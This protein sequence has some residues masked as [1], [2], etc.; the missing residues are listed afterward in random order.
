MR[1]IQI[2]DTHLSPGKAH[3]V[4]NWPP[5]ARW[6]AEQRPDLVIHTCRLTLPHLADAMAV[7]AV[8]RPPSV[9]GT[10]DSS[11][12]TPRWR[13]MD[14]NFR[15]RA[16]SDYGRAWRLALHLGLCSAPAARPRLERATKR[17]GI[18]ERRAGRLRPE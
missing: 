18:S 1:I 13:E 8:A 15:F 17:T 4:D 11:Q 5:L 7:S 6:I 16:R 14:S 10:P 12:Q 2:S 3:F 9:A